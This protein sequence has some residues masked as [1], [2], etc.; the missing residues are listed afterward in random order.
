MSDAYE[1][2]EVVS[3][4]FRATTS[5]GGEILLYNAD[6]DIIDVNATGN[7]QRLVVT[8]VAATSSA[9][10]DLVLYLDAGDDAGSPQAG[11]IIIRAEVAANGGIAKDFSTPKYGQRGAPPRVTA[12]SGTVVATLNGYL[13]KA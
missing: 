10:G 12:P 1:G 7:Q 6:G 3:G 13:L 5:T 4:E 11:E 9:A 2:K 8:D